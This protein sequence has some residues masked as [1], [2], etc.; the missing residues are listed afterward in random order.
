MGHRF[1][2]AVV[3]TSSL[4]VSGLEAGK[5]ASHP[6]APQPHP[7]A[8][9][10]NATPH[11]VP[12]NVTRPQNGARQATRG[13]PSHG[14][15]TGATRTGAGPQRVSPALRH[16]VAKDVAKILQHAAYVHHWN[17]WHYW[18]GWHG[19]AWGAY[20]YLPTNSSNMVVGVPSGNTLS[21]TNGTGGA[22]RVRLAG[23]GA[24]MLG[25]AMFS[26]SRDNLDALA[27]G[28][29]VRVFEVGTDFDGTMVAQVFLDS[30]VYLNERQIHDGMAWNDAED[31]YDLSLAGAEETAQTAGAGIWG[32]DYGANF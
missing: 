32:A 1:F 6:A 26:D 7:A 4:L 27:N 5:P 20:S 13:N 14:T 23:V 8:P 3:V 18:H 31:G 29:H 30:G 25:Q 12:H 22:Q 28:Q 2:L 24:P 19:W 21:V 11:N 17:H 16:H 15:T 9:H 10:F